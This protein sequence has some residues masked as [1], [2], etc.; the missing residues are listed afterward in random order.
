M[1]TRSYVICSTLTIITSLTNLGFG[2]A[3]FRGLNSRRKMARDIEATMYKDRYVWHTLLIHHSTQLRVEKKVWMRIMQTNDDFF[4]WAASSCRY[5]CN[6]ANHLVP[7]FIARTI[8]SNTQM[9]GLN[10]TLP[11]GTRWILLRLSPLAGRMLYIFWIALN[12][13]IEFW[14][15]YFH[16]RIIPLIRSRA[17]WIVNTHSKNIRSD[18]LILSDKINCTVRVPLA[19]CGNRSQGSRVVVLFEYSLQNLLYSSFRHLVS[20]KNSYLSADWGPKYP[21]VCGNIKVDVCFFVKKV[22]IW[23]AQKDLPEAS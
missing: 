5:V 6:G 15:I 2:A 14:H 11:E 13:D 18:M 4:S 17:I 7:L 1:K 21:K 10:V 23:S 20:W 16:F 9:P 12:I 8:K 3:P 22:T 19:L